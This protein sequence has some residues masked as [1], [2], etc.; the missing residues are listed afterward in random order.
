[1]RGNKFEKSY[2]HILESETLS[3]DSRVTESAQ[4]I[5]D[6]IPF[7]FTDSRPMFTICQDFYFNV[8][9]IF[10]KNVGFYLEVFLTVEN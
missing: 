4:K 2:I 6:S 5:V 3:R 9:R 7:I 10:Y 8:G 1:M